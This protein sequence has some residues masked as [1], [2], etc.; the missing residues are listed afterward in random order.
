MN[1]IKKAVGI[2]QTVVSSRSTDDPAA[3]GIVVELTISILMSLSSYCARS[4][5]HTSNREIDSIYHNHL[6]YIY[7]CWSYS[8]KHSNSVA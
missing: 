4:G 1:T 3:E 8:N 2:V 6:A 7:K 5:I